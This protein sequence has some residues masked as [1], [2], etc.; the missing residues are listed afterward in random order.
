MTYQT[1]RFEISDGIAHITL[2]RGD[3]INAIDHTM[4][5]EF[6]D[7]AIRC[8][9][10]ERVRAVLFDGA[11]KNFC[12]GGDLRSFLDVTGPLSEHLR[13]RT[14]LFHAAIVRLARGPAPVIVAV[15]GNV[16]GGGLAYLGVGDIVLAGAAA[17]FRV[18]Y[19][20][21]GL[22]PDGGASYT[23]AQLVG[24]RRALEL[25]LTDR[26]FDASDAER[27]GLVTRV[28]NDEELADEA[29][30]V[31]TQV[32]AGP[33]VAFASTRRLL[34]AAWTNSIEEHLDLE[35]QAIANASKTADA[36]EG[37][38]AFLEKREPRFEGQ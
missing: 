25:T 36:G 31:A 2:D 5:E 34:R 11:G 17:R 18:G 6:L 8:S 12:A 4:A 10:D 1:I 23:L 24:L 9:D 16:V 37:I 32:A 20:S 15:H 28:V 22:I 26:P 29:L 7:V 35:T 27:W 30:A 13:H 3:G 38:R 33:T 14:A 19:T 21:I